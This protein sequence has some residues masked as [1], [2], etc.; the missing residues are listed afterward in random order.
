MSL[1]NRDC[2]ELVT[3]EESRKEHFLRFYK[4]KKETNNNETRETLYSCSHTRDN[5]PDNHEAKEIDGRPNSSNDHI[6]MNLKCDVS[7]K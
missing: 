2:L 7:S 4:A 5:T 6:Q 1:G 3:L